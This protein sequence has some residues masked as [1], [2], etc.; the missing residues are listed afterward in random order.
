MICVLKN[1][2]CPSR[3]KEPHLILKSRVYPREVVH[4]NM[5]INNIVHGIPAEATDLEYKDSNL[6][7]M[8]HNLFE[9]NNEWKFTSY[10]Y[11]I[12][13]YDDEMIAETIT[14]GGYSF[15]TNRFLTRVFEILNYKGTQT[16]SKKAPN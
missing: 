2:S 15:I 5:A 11:H 8:Q 4:I 16:E 14:K 1:T 7:L 10:A 12:G 9:E 3:F 6:T 13:D